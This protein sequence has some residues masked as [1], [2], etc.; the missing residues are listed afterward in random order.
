MFLSEYSEHPRR[1]LKFSQYKWKEIKNFKRQQTEN[2]GTWEQLK[3]CVIRNH[4][5]IKDYTSTSISAGIDN[6]PC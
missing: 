5:W 1:Y 2:Q 3:S 4:Y 6:L